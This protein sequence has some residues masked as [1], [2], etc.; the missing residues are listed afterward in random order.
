MSVTASFKAQPTNAFFAAVNQI[1][2]GS[3]QLSTTAE[4]AGQIVVHNLDNETVFSSSRKLGGPAKHLIQGA[5]NAYVG[6]P[7]SDPQLIT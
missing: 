1:L 7:H 4:R 6:R 5:K 2:G 3:S